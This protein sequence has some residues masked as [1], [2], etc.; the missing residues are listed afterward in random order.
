MGRVHELKSQREIVGTW[1]RINKRRMEAIL[2]YAGNTVLDAGCSNGKYVDL[3]R[4]KGYNSYGV[5][6]LDDPAW[7]HAQQKNCLFVADISYLPFRNNDFETICAFEVLEHLADVRKALREFHRVAEKNII[8]SVPNCKQP[9]IFQKSGITFHHHIDKTHQHFFTKDELI[10]LL[11]EE[12]FS[13]IYFEYI[14]PIRPEALLLSAWHV[15]ARIASFIGQLSNYLPFRQ[16]Y[17]MTMLVV[18]SIIR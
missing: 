7:L 1:G 18:A 3:L 10:A 6:I 16:K 8:L 15:P 11:R 2:K 14:N 12:R 4:L 9:E 13:V 5:D 17:Y